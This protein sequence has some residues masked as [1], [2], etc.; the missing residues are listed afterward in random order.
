MS[1]SNNTPETNVINIIGNGTNIT[2]DINSNGDI[3]IDGILNGNLVLSG[4][5]VIGQTG[6]VNGEIQCKN[7]DISGVINGKI[8][9]AELLSL[10]STA[11]VYGDIVTNKLS[12]EPNAIFTGT[13]NMDGNSTNQ[14]VKRES[15]KE[16]ED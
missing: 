8:K 1:K 11:K 7:S 9:V 14:N 15:K 12:I 16:K 5:L 4:K 13:C 3:R 2:G 10:K 6:Q